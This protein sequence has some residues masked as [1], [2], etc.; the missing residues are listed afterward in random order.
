MLVNGEKLHI[1]DND[2]DIEYF[3]KEN[4]NI[5]DVR[6]SKLCSDKEAESGA[7]RYIKL[8][9]AP[10]CRNFF[11]KVMYHLPYEDRERILEASRKK[12]IKVP[13]KYFTYCA[14][15]ELIKLGF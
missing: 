12:G 2:K 8:L 1:N 14:K 3:L 4:I 10:E 9:N 5:N 13:K 15:R 11:L 6:R 7:E